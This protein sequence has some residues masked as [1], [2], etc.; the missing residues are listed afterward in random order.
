M[1]VKVARVDE[2][3]DDQP[4]MAEAGSKKVALFKVDGKIYALENTC[5]HR[6]GPLGEGFLEGSVVTCPWHAWQF[7]VKT[8][9]C[10]S[11]PDVAQP[12]YKVK[13]EG[14]DVFVEIP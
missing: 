7:D 12:C 2:V 6:G 5:P 4:M 13:I 1:F 8:G 3:K 14:S 9:R 10:E 11:V